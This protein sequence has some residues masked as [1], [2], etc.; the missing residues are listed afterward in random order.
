[1]KKKGIVGLILSSIL[2]L[3]VMLFSSTSNNR[4]LLETKADGLVGEPTV[5]WNNIFWGDPFNW[6][7]ET[8]PISET[9]GVPTQGYCLLATYNADIANQVYTT[10]NLLTSGIS[11]CNVAD[12]IL[13]NGVQCQNV[14][15]TAIY[16]YPQTGLF[17]YVPHN[18]VAFSDDYEYVTIQVTEGTS[19]DGTVQLVGTRFEYRGTLGSYGN[20]QINPEPIS[21]TLAEFSSIVWNNHDFNYEWCGELLPNCAPKYGYCII[22]GFKEPGKTMND[23]VIGD[24]YTKGRGVL[25]IGLNVDYKVKINGV[26]IIDV[27]G[28]KCYIF[29]YYGVFF[30]IP[31]A[32]IT[33]S[34]T[35]PYPTIEMEEGVHFNDKVNLPMVTFKFRGQL[36]QEN[37]WSYTKDP[38]TYNHFD[39]VDVASGWNNTPSDATHRQSILQFGQYGTDY[40]KNDRVSD[41]SNLVSRYSECGANITV[42]GIPLGEINESV[43]SY[44]HGYCY[45]YL[46]LPVSCLNTNTEY[47]VV[48]LHIEANTTFYDTMLPEV[49]L[50]L[51]NNQWVKDKPE[52]PDDSDYNNAFSFSNTFGQDQVVLN[53]SV[54]QITA[55]KE[56]TFNHFGLLIDY[57]LVSSDSAFVLFAAGKVNQTG[58]RLVFREKTISLFDATNGSALLGSSTIDSLEYDEWYSLFLYTKVVNE[59]LVICVAIDDVTYIHVDDVH[60]S[61]ASNL[62]NAFAIYLGNGSAAFKNNIPGEDIKKPTLSYTGKEVYGV[63][64]GSEKI[65]FSIKCSAYDSHDGDIT[66]KIICSW[67]EG[68]ITNDKINKGNWIVNIS[69]TDTAGNKAQLLVTVIATNKLEV[70]VTFDGNNPASYLIG[71]HIARI[72]A[73]IK[74]GYRFIGWYYNNQLWDFDNDYIVSDMNLTSRYQRTTDEFSVYFTVEGLGETNS[75]TLYF[76]YGTKVEVST[77]A[78]EGYSL[79]AY[80]GEE[81]VES[82]TVT[83]NLKVRLVYTSNGSSSKKKGCG[84][85][86]SSMTILIPVI[87]GITLI[88]LVILRKRGG[89]EHE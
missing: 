30:Y 83:E 89:K 3:G 29:P 63:L 78:K 42:N 81:E 67:P 79:K 18:S 19:I 24:I 31:D 87:A 8:T 68:S 36:G 13:I 85:D 49:T 56:N 50:Y 57:K 39:F 28:S 43:V 45:L 70:V 7:P 26:N 65:D 74:E 17:I 20:W 52:T 75:Y 11:G 40:L 53:N 86:I 58:L 27:E 82:I 34:E 38:S 14:S 25:G 21:R 1:M 88:G 44:L 73:P 64:A 15:G 60:I 32:S 61:S 12:H 5:N 77:F 6:K 72:A 69:I 23:S 37:C 4:S 76:L 2:T 84:G 41:A 71:D 33:Y 51:F 46:V 62:G 16:C 59:Q 22:A 10:Q 48:T 55:T 80:L 66:K 35:Y 9:G 47:R 54:R